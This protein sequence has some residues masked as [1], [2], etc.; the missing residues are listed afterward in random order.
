MFGLHRLV[1]LHWIA[2]LIV[3]TSRLHSLTLCGPKDPVEGRR[4][5]KRL[6]TTTTDRERSERPALTLSKFVLPRTATPTHYESGTPSQRE[7]LASRAGVQH[8]PN[9][10]RACE[11]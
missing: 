1:K 8:D 6:V 5:C 9:A 4:E 3:E 10:I 11:N 2:S 7:R